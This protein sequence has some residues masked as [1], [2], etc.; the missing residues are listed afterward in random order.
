MNDVPDRPHDPAEARAIELLQLVGGRTPA[1]GPRFAADIV[2]RAR[3]QRAFAGPAR[4]LGGFLAALIVALGGA[5]RATTD[6][7]RSR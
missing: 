1:L 4:A 5:I 6:R 2:T 3:A 7:R